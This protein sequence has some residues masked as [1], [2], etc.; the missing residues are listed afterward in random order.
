MPSLNSA[1]RERPH[2]CATQAEGLELPDLSLP[3]CGIGFEQ[4]VPPLIVLGLP[5]KAKKRNAKTR[6]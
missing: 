1:S 5:W 2:L 3:G 6:H 4:L